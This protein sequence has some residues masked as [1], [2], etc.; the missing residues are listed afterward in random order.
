[1]RPDKI[2]ILNPIRHGACWTGRNRA[3]RY[4]RTGRA[5]FVGLAAI[6]FVDSDLRN[7]AAAKKAADT[8]A[9]YDD[10]RRTLTVEELAHIPLVNPHK[11]LWR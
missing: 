3:E 6:Q 7:I 1:V 10:I 8:A 4:V 5:V 9:G 2:R 11:A